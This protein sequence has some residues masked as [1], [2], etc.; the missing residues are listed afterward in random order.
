M[1]K[2]NTLNLKKLRKRNTDGENVKTFHAKGLE[3][4]QKELDVPRKS[5]SLFFSVYS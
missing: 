4:F 3:L 1:M 5:S 2:G